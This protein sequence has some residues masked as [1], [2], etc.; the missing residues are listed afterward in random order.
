VRRSKT[1]SLFDQLVGAREHAPH[2]PLPYEGA[3]ATGLGKPPKSITHPLR[4]NLPIF[5]GAEGPKNVA[6]AAELCDG[7]LPL[8]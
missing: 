5:I 8:Y 1:P 7:W 6:L 3:N 2:Y 4:A